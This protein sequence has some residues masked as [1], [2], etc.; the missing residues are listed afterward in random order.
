MELSRK[1]EV[2]SIFDKRA[3]STV[4]RNHLKCVDVELYK[5][6]DIIGPHTKVKKSSL[7]KNVY[8]AEL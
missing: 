3:I 7:F 6:N 2:L 4:L 1:N 8:D 5:K